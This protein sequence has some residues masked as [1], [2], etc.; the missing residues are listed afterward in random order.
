MPRGGESPSRARDRSAQQIE[1][2]AV[3]FGLLIQRNTEPAAD[4]Q[5]G[6]FQT[7]YM[8]LGV[9]GAAV[10]SRAPCRS[11]HRD[12]FHRAE[13]L[14]PSGAEVDARIGQHS[15]LQVRPEELFAQ[16]LEG[17]VLANPEQQV[18]LLIFP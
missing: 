11:R 4:Q 3:T 9:G 18:S 2:L 5:G 6:L 13:A 14:R 15:D 10:A 7:A 17:D 8:L 1:Q 12:A 16:D